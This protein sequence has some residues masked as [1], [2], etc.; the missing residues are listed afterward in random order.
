MI[1]GLLFQRVEMGAV[2]NSKDLLMLLLYA[3]GKSGAVAE[4]ILGRTRLMKMVFL[5]DK[6]IRRQ[7]NLEHAIP[8]ETLPKFEPYHYGPFSADVYSDLEF[9]IGLEFVTK[10]EAAN[11]AAPP[12]EEASEYEHWQ[13][14]ATDDGDGAQFAQSQFALTQRGRTFVEQGRAGDLTAEQWDALDRF[15]A[16]CTGTSLTSLLRYVYEKYPSMT[17]NSKIRD[18]VMR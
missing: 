7:F 11:A 6:E 13:S 9:L 2:T 16:R 8:E 3:R 1:R 18:Q 15:K 17:A 4:P 5:F 14:G 12:D 10:S